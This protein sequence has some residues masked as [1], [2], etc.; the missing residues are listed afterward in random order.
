V[1]IFPRNQ[2]AGSREWA[3]LCPQANVS[4][5][6]VLCPTYGVQVKEVARNEERR[7]V[8]RS[9]RGV[10]LCHSP[11]CSLGGRRRH[12]TGYGACNLAYHVRRSREIIRSVVY[13]PLQFGKLAARQRRKENRHDKQLGNAAVESKPHRKRRRQILLERYTLVDT[14]PATPPTICMIKSLHARSVNI[15]CFD[16]APAA[17]CS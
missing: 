7:D 14:V 6:G 9:I 4:F 13:E 1:Q 16:A 8:L 5:V 17:C 10:L 15:F 3:C 12:L 11:Q 2:N